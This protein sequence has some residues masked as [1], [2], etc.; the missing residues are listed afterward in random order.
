MSGRKFQ[1]SEILQ[2]TQIL[3]SGAP[4]IAKLVQRTPVSLWFMVPITIVFMGFINHLITG[5]PHIVEVLDSF[6]TLLVITLRIRTGWLNPHSLRS[7][8]DLFMIN[9][10][11]QVINHVPH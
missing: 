8:H 6:H 4:Q 7:S 1:V 5:G 3:Q 9:D 10:S 11:H 2:I